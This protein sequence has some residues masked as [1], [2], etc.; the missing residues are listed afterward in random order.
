[1]VEI[2]RHEFEMA[3]MLTGRPTLKSIDKGVLW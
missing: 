2:L 1:V 3:M